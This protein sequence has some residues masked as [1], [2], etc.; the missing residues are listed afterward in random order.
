[1]TK[2]SEHDRVNQ[3]LR[4]AFTAGRFTVDGQGRLLRGP[5]EDAETGPAE[6]TDAARKPLGKSDAGARGQV[7]TDPGAAINAAIRRTLVGRG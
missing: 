5:D 4:R 2:P 1:M 6:G 7:P 3:G